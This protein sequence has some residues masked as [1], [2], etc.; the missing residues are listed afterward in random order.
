[1]PI[2]E[3]QSSGAS[4]KRTVGNLK[5]SRKG[6][7]FFLEAKMNTKISDDYDVIIVGCGIAGSLLGAILSKMERRKVLI[8]EASSQIG[9]RATSFRGE[10]IRDADEFR[11][12]LALSAHSWIS[13][14]TEPDLPTLIRKK[15][16]DGFVLEAG[17]RGAWYTNRGRVSQ[18]LALFNKASIFYSNVGFIWYDHDWK[19]YTVG[20]REKYGWMSDEDY[21]EMV[22]VHKQKLQLHNIADAEKLDHVTLKDWVE[23]ITKS[24]LAQEFHYAMGTFQT[25]INDP[26]LN[27]A[28]ENLKVFLQVMETGVHITNGSWGFAGAP[29]H[30][31]ITEGFA[32]AVTYAGGDILTSSRVK[33]VTIANKKVTGVVAEIDGKDRQIK[34]PVVVCTVPPK[35]LLKLIPESLLPADFVKLTKNVIH[36]SMVAGQFGM[37]RQL[38]DF[39]ELE[40]DPRSFYHTSMLIP[41][42]EGLFRGNV[43]LDVV[44]MSTIAPTSAPEGKHLVGMASSILAEEAHDKKKVDIVIDRMLKFADT[45]FKGW[46][47][48]LEFMLFTVG[49]T[50]ILWRHP[51]DDWVDVKCPTIDGLYFA[52]DTYGKRLNEGGIE[53]AAHSAFI[54]AGAITGKDYLDLLPPV[55]R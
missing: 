44:S 32:T 5:H 37:T 42:S 14:R 19:P 24:E 1:M 25:I 2:Q 29:G 18:A 21:A 8:L 20:R 52:G 10:S 9:G 45:A 28:G 17:G 23:S 50:C 48:S 33:E 15:M 26:A 38:S 41:E 36:T 11:K 4:V 49:D 47:K 31:F 46:R 16:L 53:G 35:V 22:K 34:S 51:E 55:F 13:D 6:R 40:V 43:P 7:H 12:A 39:C 30:R 27:S 3:R 54:C